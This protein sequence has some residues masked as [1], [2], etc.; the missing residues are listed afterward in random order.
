MSPKREQLAPEPGNPGNCLFTY[1]RATAADDVAISVEQSADL[2]A[3]TTVDAAALV[4]VVESGVTTTLVYRIP[5]PPA[6]GQVFA[7][8][9]VLKL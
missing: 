5:M 1:Q 6:G 2:V 7:R 9:K 4:S 8:L 3:W